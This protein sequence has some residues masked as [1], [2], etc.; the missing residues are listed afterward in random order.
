MKKEDLQKLRPE[1]LA[2]GLRDYIDVADGGDPDAVELVDE[3]ER[4]LKEVENCICWGV[5]CVHQAKSLDKS[6]EAYTALQSYEDELRN[7]GDNP[8]LLKMCAQGAIAHARMA[9]AELRQTKAT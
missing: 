1:T 3:M 6:Y 9:E 8:E 7:A 4:R 5:D 2:K